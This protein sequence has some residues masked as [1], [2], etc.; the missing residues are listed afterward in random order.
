LV[1][2]P[3]VEWSTADVF[4]GH[5]AYG[6]PLHEAYRRYGSSRLSCAFCVLA[7]AADLGAAASAQG[8]RDLYRHLVAIEADSTFSFQPA[9]WLADVAPHLLSDALARQIAD[10]KRAASERRAL[11][12]G[13]PAELRFV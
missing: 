7:S 8:N 3:L 4:A 13:M 1:W 6:L 5:D 9:R 2:H 12:G 10:A 11:E